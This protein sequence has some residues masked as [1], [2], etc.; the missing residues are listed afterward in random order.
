MSCSSIG[1]NIT[2]ANAAV[3]SVARVHSEAI[4]ARKPHVRIF[5]TKL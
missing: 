2:L 3:I 1:S 4:D 5:G